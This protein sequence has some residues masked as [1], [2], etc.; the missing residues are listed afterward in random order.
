MSVVQ[1]GW[2]APNHL[3][4]AA[5]IITAKFKNLRNTLKVWQ[6]S[7]SNLKLVIQNV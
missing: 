7:L 6:R 2:V 4:D 5:K 1:N 3:T